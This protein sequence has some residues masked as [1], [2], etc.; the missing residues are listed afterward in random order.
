MNQNNNSDVYVITGAVGGIGM[1]VARKL[2]LQKKRVVITDV[3]DEAKG[4]AAAEALSRE[5]GVQVRY[6]KLDVSDPEATEALANKLEQNGWPVY[7]LMANAG[8]APSSSAIDYADDLWRKTMAINL[9]GVFWSCRAFARGMLQ[10]QHGA[11][12]ITSSIAGLGVVRPETHAAYGA[13]KAAVSHLAALLGVEWAEKGVRVNAVAP[14]Y[15]ETPILTKLKEE[16]PDVFSTWMNDTPMKRLI[17]P[18]EIANAV[19][20]LFSDE[21]SGITATTLSVDGGYAAR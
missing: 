1:A 12:V 7:G 17:K 6:E 4:N 19:A 10:R 18:E 11:I 2:A 3:V 20:F 15:T 8:I 9:D 5:A 21:A 16:S 13:S 14:G